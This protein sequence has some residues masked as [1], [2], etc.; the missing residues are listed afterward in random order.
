MTT[1]SN[2][3]SLPLGWKPVNQE[4]LEPLPMP[5]PLIK[6]EGWGGV[7]TTLYGIVQR[8]WTVVVEDGKEEFLIEPL[9]ILGENLQS[10]GM[11]RHPANDASGFSPKKWLEGCLELQDDFPDVPSLLWEV[12]NSLGGRP[13]PEKE[14]AIM[15]VQEHLPYPWGMCDAA[16]HAMGKSFGFNL[17][18]EEKLRRHSG[19]ILLHGCDCNHV[20]KNLMNVRSM[21]FPTIEDDPSRFEATRAWLSHFLSELYQ[22]YV[23]GLPFRL[24]PET[25]NSVQ[26]LSFRPAA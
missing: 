14:E 2:V 18:V 24:N 7:N 17:H 22:I 19:H 26:V 6:A 5:W 21:S 20:V 9:K 25:V 8:F 13:E 10:A 15:N 23:V 16:L 1:L 3:A 4:R 11:S 12:V